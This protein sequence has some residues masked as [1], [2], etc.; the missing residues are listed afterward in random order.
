[1]INRYEGLVDVGNSNIHPILQGHQST[2]VKNSKIY[3]ATY[4]LGW[5]SALFFKK[6][7]DYFRDFAIKKYLLNSTV[8]NPTGN[9]IRV[10]TRGVDTCTAVAILRGSSLCLLHL[11]E[12]H[13]SKHGQGIIECTMAHI[14]DDI[15]NAYVVTSHINDS[16]ELSFITALVEE[17][18]D[19]P[20]NI[21]NNIKINRG[22][23]SIENNWM[24][25]IE[26][27]IA[28]DNDAL[29]VYGDKVRYS[30]QTAIR[31]EF[32]FPFTETQAQINIAMQ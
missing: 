24:R 10:V 19:I 16:T 8:E 13:L 3:G 20:L 9:I 14:R 18:K 1:M 27:G 21:A 23:V 5:G 32:V 26:F 11:D 7:G 15:G 2:G 29:C 12:N 31:N 6:A 17:C 22:N 30:G 25:H 4:Q 28:L